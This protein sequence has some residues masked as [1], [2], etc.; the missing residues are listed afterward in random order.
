MKGDKTGSHIQLLRNFILLRSNIFEKRVILRVFAW[1]L[2]GELSEVHSESRITSENIIE[3]IT[4]SDISGRDADL[5]H[6]TV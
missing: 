2:S 5:V 3:E 1:V 6:I 4:F